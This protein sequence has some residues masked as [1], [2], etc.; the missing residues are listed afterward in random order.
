MWKNIT[1]TLIVL[2]FFDAKIVCV[3]TNVENVVI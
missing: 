1:R 2:I 3:L